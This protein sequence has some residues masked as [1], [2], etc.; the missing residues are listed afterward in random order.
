M[1]DSLRIQFLVT[2]FPYLQGLTAVPYGLA[3][4]LA[5]VWA[6]SLSRRAGV[7]DVLTI[8]AAV[9]ALLLIAWRISHHYE[10]AFGR[11]VALPQ[12]RR[13]DLLTSLG[14]AVLALG[15]FWLDVTV[16]LPLSFIGLVCA[17][18]LLTV[19]LRGAWLA[20]GRYLL[21]YPLLSAAGILISVL[22]ALG[23]PAWWMSVGFRSQLLAVC[24]AMGLLFIVAGVV[25]H[26]QLLRILSRDE[27][28]RHV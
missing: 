3:L 17:L 12:A 6:N 20:T 7:T 5:A 27:G 4:A 26:A 1:Q 22:P 23:W 15:A 10:R 25:S 11:A 14:G 8:S 9:V 19:F 18:A 13:I 2:S 28:Q 16:N 21:Y 24:A